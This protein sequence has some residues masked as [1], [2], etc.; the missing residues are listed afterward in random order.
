[1]PSGPVSPGPAM[2][3]HVRR[4]VL[5]QSWIHPRTG[6]A[7]ELTRVVSVTSWPTC[8]VDADG[9]RVRV[10]GA[11][12]PVRAISCTAM[13]LRPSAAVSVTVARTTPDSY[14]G[15]C[16]VRVAVEATPVRQPGLSSRQA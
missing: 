1:M 16:T 8:R 14:D 4:S 6:S 12:A 9:D 5:D 15:H 10:S 13:A 11:V 3:V 7:P 2:V